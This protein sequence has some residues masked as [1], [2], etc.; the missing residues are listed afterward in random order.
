MHAGLCCRLGLLSR[1]PH[2]AQGRELNQIVSFLSMVSLWAQN[3][4]LAKLLRRLVWHDE[5]GTLFE[6]GAMAPLISERAVRWRIVV[7]GCFEP[8]SWKV[9][10]ARWQWQELGSVH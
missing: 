6:C 3:P 10:V 4:T 2:M 1:L 8:G 9:E 7:S 5:R